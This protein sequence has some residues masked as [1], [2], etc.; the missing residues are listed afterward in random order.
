MMVRWLSERSIRRG[1]KNANFDRF[2]AH[3]Q[4][5]TWEGTAAAEDDVSGDG[6][7]RLIL[8]RG[9]FDPGKEFLAAV[10]LHVT[11]EAR[12]PRTCSITAFVADRPKTEP[13]A[14]TVSN[15][16]SP[17]RVREVIVDDLTLVDFFCLF[18]RSNVFLTLNHFNLVGRPFIRKDQMKVAP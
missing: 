8:Q 10:S 17:L 14:A 3:T 5:D 1:G 7:S 11:A 12:K 6:I 13:L 16:R 9:L 4:V 15:Q 18:K 2:L